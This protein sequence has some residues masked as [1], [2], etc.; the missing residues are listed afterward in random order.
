MILYTLEISDVAGLYFL[1]FFPGVIL[2]LFGLALM[3]SPDPDMYI[4]ARKE[5]EDP[6]IVPSGRYND[7]RCGPSNIYANAGDPFMSQTEA[8]FLSRDQP[9]HG[10]I[11][12]RE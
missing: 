8:N 7:D 4:E 9:F 11:K 5:E 1:I 10:Q 3:V 12:K 2:F 6:D